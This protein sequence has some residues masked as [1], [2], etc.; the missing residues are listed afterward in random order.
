MDLIWGI[1]LTILYPN[2]FLYIIQSKALPLRSYI[3][4]QSFISYDVESRHCFIF[5]TNFLTG[6]CRLAF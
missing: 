3:N 4:A 1:R 5:N 6:Y 2:T